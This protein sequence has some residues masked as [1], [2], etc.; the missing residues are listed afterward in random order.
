MINRDVYTQLQPANESIWWQMAVTR[1]SEHIQAQRED[2]H[3]S[4]RRK[5]SPPKINMLPGGPNQ[6]DCSRFCGMP[7]MSLGACLPD[8][9]PLRRTCAA[10]GDLINSHLSSWRSLVQL[11]CW[12]QIIST[13]QPLSIVQASS[14]RS[15]IPRVD[16]LKVPRSNRIKA[17]NKNHRNPVVQQSISV[18]SP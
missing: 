1:Q 15:N 5:A 17:N 14:K 2:F 7:C 18:N 4:R 6:T 11:R 8:S 12:L 16:D 13:I 9:W 10:E 3:L